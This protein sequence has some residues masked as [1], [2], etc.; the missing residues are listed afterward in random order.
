VFKI[1]VGVVLLDQIGLQKRREN[2]QCPFYRI[3]FVEDVLLASKYK[4]LQGCTLNET[5]DFMAIN[6]G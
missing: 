2:T 5:K 3:E 4:A 6:M 1:H